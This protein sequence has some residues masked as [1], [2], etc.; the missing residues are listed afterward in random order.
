MGDF[1]GALVIAESVLEVEPSDAEA[2]RMP[3]AAARC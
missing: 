1:T 3:R 2:Q